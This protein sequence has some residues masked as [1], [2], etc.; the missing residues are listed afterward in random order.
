MRHLHAWL[1]TNGAINRRPD[2][3]GLIDEYVHQSCLA[4]HL[5]FVQRADVFRAICDTGI[6]FEKLIPISNGYWGPEDA[7]GKHMPGI[8]PT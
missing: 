1:G 3:L 7:W 4:R 2:A 5:G 6:R 8:R